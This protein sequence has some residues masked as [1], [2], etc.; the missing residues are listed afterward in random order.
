MPVSHDSQMKEGRLPLSKWKSTPGVEGIHNHGNTCFMNTIIQCLSS[1]DTF[2]EY[3]IKR[4]FK[5]ALS[6]KG[7]KKLV[8]SNKGEVSEQLAN[9]LE[10]LWSGHY[11]AE[12]SAQFKNVVSKYNAQYKGNSQHDAQEF[13]LWLLDRINEEIHQNGKKMWKENASKGKK[14]KVKGISFTQSS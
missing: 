4:R 6:T 3:F 1:T 11:N 2:T 9:L 7:L 8:G 12:V 5:D 14:D 13:L 10:S